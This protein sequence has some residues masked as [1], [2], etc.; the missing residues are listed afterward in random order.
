MG[1]YHESR[2]SMSQGRNNGLMATIVEMAMLAMEPI[3]DGND[4]LRG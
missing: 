4:G 2:R 3:L 1:Q